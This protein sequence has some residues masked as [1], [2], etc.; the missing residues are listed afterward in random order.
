MACRWSVDTIF[1]SKKFVVPVET[2][3][4]LLCQVP[5]F[6]Q[7]K[8]KIS[9]CCL[10]PLLKKSA[11]L[12][13]P[14]PNF[15]RSKD[16]D[17]INRFI[18]I[19]QQYLFATGTKRYRTGGGRLGGIGKS[20]VASMWAGWWEY[21]KWRLVWLSNGGAVAYHGALS[22]TMTI[23]RMNGPKMCSVYTLLPLLTETFRFARLR[24]LSF[25]FLQYML[26]MRM[27]YWG[28]APA[29]WFHS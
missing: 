28:G 2:L 23:R 16:P 24:P 15:Q 9:F 21:C 14:Q 10:T 20:A 25:I 18:P 27:R 7:Q 13:R 1:T 6:W 11:K 12:P 4:Y 5:N 22:R 8:G 29:A 3:Q 17:R 26:T 19:Q